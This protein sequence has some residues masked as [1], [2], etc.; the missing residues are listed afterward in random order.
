MG[1]LVEIEICELERVMLMRFARL[2]EQSVGVS[3]CVVN[4]KF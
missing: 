3:G 1:S 4:I 2:E